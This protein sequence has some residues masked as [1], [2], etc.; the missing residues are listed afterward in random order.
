MTCW[1]ASGNQVVRDGG[2]AFRLGGNSHRGVIES[3]KWLPSN[4]KKDQLPLARARVKNTSKC[5]LRL[6]SHLHHRVNLP[7]SVAGKMASPVR[8]LIFERMTNIEKRSA[9]E[10]NGP[11]EI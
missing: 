1:C 7:R 4:E 3:L 5:P 9:N 11:L 8:V 6:D 10:A 2:V